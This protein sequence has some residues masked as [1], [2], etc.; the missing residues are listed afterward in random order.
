MQYA[1]HCRT[2]KRMSDVAEMKGAPPVV[3]RIICMYHAP[4]PQEMFSEKLSTWGSKI[5]ESY[6]D[7]QPISDW[8]LSVPMQNGNPDFARVVPELKLR[9][10]Y[11]GSGDF[12]D[13]VWC[14]QCL[15]NAVCFNVRRERANIHGYAELKKRAMALLPEWSEHFD[16]RR[17]LG[18]E[19]QYVNRLN[20]ELTPQFM[21]QPG[22]LMIG[23]VF[24]LLTNIPMPDYTIVQPYDCTVTLTKEEIPQSKLTV[25]VVAEK[26]GTRSGVA[27]HLGCIILPD[28]HDFDGQN[29][30]NLLDIAHDRA[31]DAFRRLFTEYALKTFGLLP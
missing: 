16:V 4:I 24:K 23:K 9:Y 12:D 21:E 31:N 19:V 20:A 13:R 25:R 30:A 22:R 14:V 10:R 7:V 8:N 6:P 17:F 3:E 2:G 5:G 29:A 27:I 26:D 18:A 1:N 15:P 11:W 28:D